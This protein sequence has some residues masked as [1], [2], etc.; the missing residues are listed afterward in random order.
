MGLYASGGI[1]FVHAGLNPRA[2]LD[3]FL[4]T[5]MNASFGRAAFDPDLHWAGVRG[6]FLRHA[7]N[8]A[9]GHHGFFVVHGHSPRGR[10]DQATDDWAVAHSRLNL[11][12]GSAITGRARMAVIRGREITVHEASR[13]TGEGGP[14]R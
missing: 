2:N 11:D 4:G 3:G 6:P 10:E 14:T 13:S 1:L 8:A 9:E 5:P 12:A 7:P